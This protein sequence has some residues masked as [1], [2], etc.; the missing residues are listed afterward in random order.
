[1]L[2]LDQ[3]NSYGFS[4]AVVK[5]IDQTYEDL[6]ADNGDIKVP[7]FNVLIPTVQ[8]V[9][10]TNVLEL[11]QPGALD[12][13]V[14]TH[15]N[16]NALKYGFGPDF[17][18]GILERGNSNVGVY[19]INLRGA[20]ASMANVVVLMKYRIE[21]AVPYTDP[22]GNQYYKDEN[23]Q[24]TT[25]PVEGGAISRDVLHVRFVTASVA[26]CKKWSDLYKGMNAAYSQ[27]ADDNGYFTIPWFGVMYRGATAYGNNVY[28]N[29]I[30]QRA[31]FDGNMYYKIGMFNG[32]TRKTSDP[33]HS[34]EFNSGVKYNTSYYM[35]NTFNRDYPVLRYVTAENSQDII[36]LFNQYLYTVD[37][38]I[39]GTHNTPE[40]QFAAIDPFNAD[41][42]AIVVDT[43]SLN[44]QVT[45]AFQLSGGFDGTE[46][47]D[48]LFCQFF[49]GEILGDITSPLRYRVNYIPDIGYDQETKV[50]IAKLI[51]KRIRM[52]SSTIMLGGEDSFAS[53]LIDH[54]ANWYETEPNI[55]QLAKYQS[56]MRYNPFTRRTMVHP[57][58][59]FDTMALME[60]F[61][62][63]GHF[64][65][66]F[67]GAE[68]RWK[69]FIEDTMPYLV[70]EPQY[71]QSYHA[72]RINTVM[73]D[74]KDGAYLADQQMNTVRVSDQTELNNAFLI[75]CMLYDL[76]DLIH[77]NHFKFNEAEEV[78]QFDE[79]VNDC[80][81]QKYKKHS[82][83]ISAKVERV[84]TVGRA[85]SANK[86]IVT[87]DLKDINKYTDIEL[88]LVDE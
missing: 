6:Y 60:H 29:L 33:V 63:W 37:E 24:I 44:P 69:D 16:P 81:N 38:Y 18:H 8:E 17:I 22:D 36:D 86:I 62:K 3:A 61:A 21:K 47:R 53:A 51:K 48:E 67:A 56:P 1:M 23:N 59:Y 14:A 55:R 15:G 70:E 50:A 4:N 30:P 84:G 66:P 72:M 39:L 31:E 7:D 57:A 27:T 54:Q 79:A 45:N 41:N 68:A 12:H 25:D 28:F 78:R 49:N 2:I 9:G 80:I 20:S 26:D 5:V 32:Q 83:S 43:G 42:F 75:S 11:Y 71:L 65:Q 19:T 13:Y 34:F 74:S 73:K 88:Y 52:T 35:E 76:V 64:F 58:S 85:K 77:Y 87:V 10:I 46:T 40:L 82:A